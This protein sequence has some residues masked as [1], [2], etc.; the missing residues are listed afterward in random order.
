MPV[1]TIVG[2]IL[3]A[4]GSAGVGYGLWN[5]WQGASSPKWPTVTGQVVSS[6][7]QRSRDRQGMVTYR[8]EVAYKYE[9][10]GQTYASDRV[11]FGDQL[12]TSWATGPVREVERYHPGSQV[13]V[14]YDPNKPSRSVLEP[15]APWQVYV[16]L[17]TAAAFLGFGIAVL[18]GSVPV[19]A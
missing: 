4:G 15:G 13:Q 9:V 10:G 3:L 11:F 18:L 19:N 8:A 17:F 16:V 1:A 2:A 7:L 6:D 5:L 12:Q 14:F